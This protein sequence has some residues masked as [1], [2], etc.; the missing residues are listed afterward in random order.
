MWSHRNSSNWKSNS[1][2]LKVHP[3]LPALHNA[4]NL[5]HETQKSLHKYLLLNLILQVGLSR[6]NRSIDFGERADNGALVRFNA[7]THDK[8]VVI[9]LQPEQMSTV[10]N[11]Q[12]MTAT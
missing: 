5:S 10:F 1:R 7:H 12:I 11:K 6:R 9:N 2:A 3:F 8:E 4:L